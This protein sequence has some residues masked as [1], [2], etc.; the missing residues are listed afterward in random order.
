MG[1][2]SKWMG[3]WVDDVKV[4]R[5]FEREMESGSTEKGRLMKFF[6]LRPMGQWSENGHE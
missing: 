1:G 5:S 2:V 3:K 4:V 6:L